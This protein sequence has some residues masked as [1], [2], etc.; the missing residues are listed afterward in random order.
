VETL[1]RTITRND[2]SRYKTICD[3]LI[4]K[5]KI[6]DDYNN[7]RILFVDN[8][9][10]LDYFHQEITQAIGGRFQGKLPSQAC[11]FASKQNRGVIAIN[12]DGLKNK[13][14]ENCEFIILE[15]FCHLLDEAASDFTQSEQFL[16]FCNDY[17][18]N[19]GSHFS[20]EISENL[21]KH[22][23]HYYVNKLMLTF[24]VEKW[25]QFKSNSYSQKSRAQLNRLIAE[26]RATRP[27]KHYLAIIT[28][29]ILQILC[30]VRSVESFLAYAQPLEIQKQRLI[31]FKNSAIET[32]R[33]AEQNAKAVDKTYPSTIEYFISN[34][35]ISKDSFFIRV[36]QLWN[37]LHL[38][39]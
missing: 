31:T 25:L 4:A 1:Y 11:A 17:S 9:S 26:T 16:G 38:F 35:F 29:E 32:V 8:N 23:D 15:K 36:R 6:E 7:L 22:Y 37:Y 28:T 20:S 33:F 12:T 19:V 34:D 30:L 24:D 3:E 18:K 10:Y 13:T 27:S 5:T 2:I 14:T 21:N 39:E